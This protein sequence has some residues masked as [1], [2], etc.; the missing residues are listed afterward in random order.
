MFLQKNK[1][2]FFVFVTLP[3]YPS[4][5]SAWAVMK[6]ARHTQ[7]I[8]RMKSRLLQRP[9][10]AA[11]R[12][13][14]KGAKDCESGHYMIMMG[15]NKMSSA[16]EQVRGLAS[17]PPSFQNPHHAYTP[18]GDFGILPSLVE[19]FSCELLV[20]LLSITEVFWKDFPV[21]GLCGIAEGSLRQG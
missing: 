15:K 18:F 3:L 1:N 13:R 4:D 2:K 17:N 19:K 16:S 6:R 20:G 5:I 14:R 12:L 9:T 21:R 10:E 7:Q 11:T 8:G